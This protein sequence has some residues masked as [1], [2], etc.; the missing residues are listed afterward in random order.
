MTTYLDHAATS[1]LRPE[2][3]EAYTRALALVGNPS[4]VHGAGQRARAM[5][6][7]ARERIAAVVGCNRN[8]VVFTSGGTESDNL[9]IKGLYAMRG[10]PLIITAPTEHHAVIDAVEYLEKHGAEVHWLSVSENGVIDLDELASVLEARGHETALITLMTVNNETGVITPMREV[11]ELAKQHEVPVH[12]DAVAAFGHTAINFAETGLDA[13][14]ITAHKLGGPV[15]V[16]ALIVARKTKLEPLIHGGNQE[17]G[18]RSGTMD[19]AGAQAFAKAAELGQ[20]DYRELESLA[21]EIIGPLGRHTRG[22]APGV[23][24]ILNFTFE[25]CE[26]DSLLF[27]LDQKGIEVSNGSACTAGVARASHVLLGMGY[28]EDDAASALRISF[29]PQTTGDDIRLLAAE[30]PSVLATARKI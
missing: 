26:G 25:G 1:P 3:L 2:V 24:N 30:L 10:K 19:A 14:S 21:L 11:T 23:P 6:E 7:D 16:G 22:S 28:S 15:G 8:E 9:A 20:P 4:A 18:F 13:M 27:L 17:R 29:G 12:S 5:L